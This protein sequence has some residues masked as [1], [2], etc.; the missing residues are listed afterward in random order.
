[1]KFLI[2][3][4]NVSQIEDWFLTCL[5]A[6]SGDLEKRLKLFSLK[7]KDGLEWLGQSAGLN[8]FKKFENKLKIYATAIWGID[9]NIKEIQITNTK[10]SIKRTAFSSN[11]LRVNFI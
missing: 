8:N 6:S 9:I 2:S 5:R 7:D 3:K 10:T 1:M 4:L 11:L